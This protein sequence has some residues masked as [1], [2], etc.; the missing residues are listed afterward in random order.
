[1]H[2]MLDKR[3]NCYRYVHLHII[4][5][6]LITTIIGIINRNTHTRALTPSD[7]S[8]VHITISDTLRM[9]QK[10]LI[11]VLLDHVCVQVSNRQKGFIT[12]FADDT[13]NLATVTARWRRGLWCLGRLSRRVT[14]PSGVRSH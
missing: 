7:T 13:S 9:T 12:E 8:S 1:M 3:S 10:N 11:R 5:T 2:F 14:G 6:L 4:H